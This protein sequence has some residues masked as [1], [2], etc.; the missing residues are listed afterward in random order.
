MFV[1]N[2]RPKS[3]VD[4]NISSLQHHMVAMLE[5]LRWKEVKEALEA[6]KEKDGKL[7]YAH[8]YKN[9]RKA[10]AHWM[11]KSVLCPEEASAQLA[12]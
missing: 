11:I 7:S 4:E 5:V 1:G 12:H 6:L 3:C 2:P 9:L 10:G 8:F